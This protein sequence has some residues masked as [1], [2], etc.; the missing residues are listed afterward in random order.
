MSSLHEVERHVGAHAERFSAA[1]V[2]KPAGLALLEDPPAIYYLA[3]R[4]AST[5]VDRAWAVTPKNI[6]TNPLAR[7]AFA[8]KVGKKLFVAL[9]GKRNVDSSTPHLHDH[10]L[11]VLLPGHA[12]LVTPSS[13]S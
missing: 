6:P 7:E 8:A 13:K 11:Y 4:Q 10:R 9:I 1:R 2:L 12:H 3:K 5:L